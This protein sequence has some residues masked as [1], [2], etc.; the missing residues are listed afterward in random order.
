M[1]DLGKDSE[2]HERVWLLL[3]WYVNDTLETAERRLVDD[4]LA[5]CPSCREEAARCKGLAA[6]LRGRQESAP[7]PHPIQLARLMERV[8]ASERGLEA[9]SE[10]GVEGTGGASVVPV[11]LARPAG[12][13][14]ARRDR[15]GQPGLPASRLLSSTPRPVRWALAGQLAALLLL[16]AALAL[17]PA[18]R[19]QSGAGVPAAQAGTRDAKYVTLS[20]PAANAGSAVAAARPQIRLMFTETATEKQMRDVLLAAR[21]RLVDGPSPAGTYTLELPAPTS[22][23]AAPPDP[24]ARAATPAASTASAPPETRAGAGETAPA[25]PAPPASLA[26]AA[27]DSVGT[28]LAYLRSQPIVRFAEPVAGTPSQLASPA[29]P[30]AP[31]GQGTAHGSP[32]P[33]RP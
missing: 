3:P 17:G 2:Q 1:S 23:A 30:A 31:A 13:T 12:N 5:A 21:G 18:R 15:R 10:D 22:A 29:W 26:E 20:A 6:A 4:H 24:V 33:P 11:P 32:A 14:T 25:P 19:T 8:E 28:I 16:A 27:P 7:S 9:L